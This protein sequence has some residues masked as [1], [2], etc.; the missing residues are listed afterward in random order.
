MIW[1]SVYWKN[2]LIK[3][4]KKI[5]ARLKQ[6]RWTDASN[7]NSEKEIMIAA[8]ISRKLFDSNKISQK[9]ENHELKIV[10]YKSNGKRINLLRRL[11]PDKYFDLENPIN[12]SIKFRTLCNQIIHSYIF[13]LLMNEHG[14]LTDFWVASDYDK[15]KFMYQISVKSYSSQLLKIGQYWPTQESYEF[16][17]HKNDYIIKHD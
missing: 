16:D 6:I 1:E 3:L 5:T 4:N 15:F 11:S 9:L 10:K 12:G 14:S 8:F 7:A 17:Q 13:M 2:D